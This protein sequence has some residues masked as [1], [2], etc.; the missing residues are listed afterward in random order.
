MRLREF[1]AVWLGLQAVAT[2]S[3]VGGG[4]L[5]PCGHVLKSIHG[6]YRVCRNNPIFSNLGS[7]AECWAHFMCHHKLWPTSVSHAFSSLSGS[8]GFA[9][10]K[11]EQK[12]T[13]LSL[14]FF[15]KILLFQAAFLI[16][17]SV[18]ALFPYILLVG[19]FLQSVA[20]VQSG[21]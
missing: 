12:N 4:H 21:N 20:L 9:G 2:F 5:Q 13:I 6:H 17:C 14:G 15:F 18:T 3:H 7:C 10:G 8:F 16:F 19:V 1:L 11:H